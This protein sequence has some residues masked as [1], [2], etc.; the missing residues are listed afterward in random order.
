MWAFL[1]KKIDS[2][3]EDTKA[4]LEVIEQSVDIIKDAMGHSKHKKHSKADVYA[5]F[6]L[7]SAHFHFSTCCSH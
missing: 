1:E 7:L 4:S 3:N 6:V 5:D 2:V